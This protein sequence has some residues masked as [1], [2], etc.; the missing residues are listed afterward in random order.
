MKQMRRDK[1]LYWDAAWKLV[2]GCSKVSDG[3]KYCWSEQET[4]IR[5]YHPH[6]AIAER[7][8]QV[9]SGCHFSGRVGL[10]HDNL[11]L[12]LRTKKPTVFAV[13]N[14]L[15]HKDVPD[16]F[17]DR[18]YAVMALCPQHT[19]LVLTKRAERMLAYWSTDIRHRLLSAS[20]QVVGKV[21]TDWFL[22]ISGPTSW[23]LPN[24]WH[25]VTCEDQQRADERIPHLLRV[26]GN[27][28]LSLEP[29]LGP[30]DL[31]PWMSGHYMVQGSFNLGISAVLLGGES[32]KNARPMHT[33]WVDLVR[34]R[35]RDN[36]VP[37]F[38]KQWGEFH[39]LMW[40]DG[41]DVCIGREEGYRTVELDGTT[42]VRCGKRAAGRHL[43]GVLHN[44]LPWDEVAK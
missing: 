38:F 8:R 35:C 9:L 19:F 26:P 7:A 23:P 5:C 3:C 20:E 33:N 44:A 41:G 17:R 4:A 30:V 32:G 37:F 10:R 12:P 28:F 40:L 31:S 24:V 27:R 13:W 21:K 22:R 16:D 18:A 39:P 15:Y 14:D 6:P 2:E 34:D 11:D 25:G 29:L 1:G 42:M 43:D 36:G